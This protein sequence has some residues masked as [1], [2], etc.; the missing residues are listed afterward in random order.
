MK[1]GRPRGRP[2]EGGSRKNQRAM[3]HQRAKQRHAR[4]RRES[5]QQLQLVVILDTKFDLVRF[6]QGNGDHLVHAEHWTVPA[7]QQGPSSRRGRDMCERRPLLMLNMRRSCDRAPVEAP[8]SRR[9]RGRGQHPRRSARMLACAAAAARRCAR[10]GIDRAT[11]S[12]RRSRGRRRRP[13]RR[14]PRGAALR[15][16]TPPPRAAAAGPA[17]AGPSFQPIALRLSS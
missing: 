1:S 4:A 7:A 10:A 16:R 15:P 17:G 2:G 3:A 9:R 11:K 5:H 8:R 12:G 14:A 13:A 6:R